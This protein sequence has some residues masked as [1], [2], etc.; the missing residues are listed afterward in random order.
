MTKRLPIVL[1]STEAMKGLKS[2][3]WITWEELLQDAYAVVG[4]GE[5]SWI[6]SIPYILKS[7]LEWCINDSHLCIATTGLEHTCHFKYMT[8]ARP[9]DI[10]L[11]IWNHS[12]L[13]AE[14]GE[15]QVLGKLRQYNEMMFQKTKTV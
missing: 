10:C 12:S 15:L 6:T 11:H 3:L 1:S 4:G 9:G 2:P 13:E 5:P 14:S 7:L 8:I